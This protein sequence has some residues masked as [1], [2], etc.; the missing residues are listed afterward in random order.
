MRHLH[1]QQR[2][3]KVFWLALRFYPHSS[4]ANTSRGASDCIIAIPA[5]EPP[6][7]TTGLVRVRLRRGT[8]RCFGLD[9]H[10]DWVGADVYVPMIYCTQ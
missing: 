3:A 7:R 2:R 9:T 4:P 8:G 6:S 10:G 5:R 1:F